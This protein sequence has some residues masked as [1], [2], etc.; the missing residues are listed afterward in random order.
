MIKNKILKV[1]NKEGHLAYRGIRIQNDFF[2]FFKKTWSQMTLEHLNY[3][4]EGSGAKF[5]RFKACDN[6]LGK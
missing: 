2:F 5:Q 3:L 1:D 4:L 6:I